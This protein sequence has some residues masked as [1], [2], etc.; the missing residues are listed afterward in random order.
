MKEYEDMQLANNILTV[1]G[2]LICYGIWIFTFYMSFAFYSV[3]KVQNKAYVYS[4]FITVGLDFVGLELL[5]EL[6]LAIIYMQRKSSKCLRV[7]G[8][9]LNRLRNHRCLN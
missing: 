3:W 6:F 5:Y 4:F 7:I 9:F 8:E 2:A 1:V